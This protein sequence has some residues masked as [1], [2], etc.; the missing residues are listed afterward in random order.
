M[1]GVRVDSLNKQVKLPAISE[2]FKEP[3]Q[4]TG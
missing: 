3:N 1:R 2:P 4:Q